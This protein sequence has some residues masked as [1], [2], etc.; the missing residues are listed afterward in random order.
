MLVRCFVV[1]AIL[2]TGWMSPTMSWAAAA[3]RSDSSTTWATRTN[4]TCTAPAGIQNGDVLILAFAIGENSPPTPTAPSGFALVSGTWPIDVVGGLFHVHFRVWYKIASGESG[5]YT[6]THA[7]A[8]SQC[9]IKAVSGGSSSQPAATTNSGTGTT[10][11]ASTIT[12]SGNDSLVLF[13]AHDWGST[14]NALSPPT[15]TTPT[16]TERLDPGT[17]AGIMYAADGVLSTAGATGN[18]TQTN[19][20]VGSDPW[21]ASLVV[22]EASGGGGS[23]PPPPSRMMMGVG[24]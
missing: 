23:P 16:F 21:A 5:N 19:N 12:P 11:T 8:S 20:S 1:A 7:S 2:V 18:K 22:V 4:T 17:V 10:T 13:V 24:K 9:Y 3:H 6:V 15:G 14:A